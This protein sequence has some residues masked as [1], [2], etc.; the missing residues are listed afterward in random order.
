MRISF[1]VL[2]GLLV[3]GAVASAAAAAEPVGDWNVQDKSAVIRIANCRGAL[4]GVVAWERTPNRDDNNPN[5]QLK[6]RPMLGNAILLGMKQTSQNLWEG[7]IYNPRNGKNYSSKIKMVGANGLRVEGCVMGFLCGG[8][9]WTRAPQAAAVAAAGA[10]AGKAGAPKGG[11]V[12][13]CS[14]VAGRPH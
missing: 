1:L 13:V 5:P 2:S 9:D 4:W 14:S 12:D 10:G 6:G 7:Q 11:G 3:V 8:E